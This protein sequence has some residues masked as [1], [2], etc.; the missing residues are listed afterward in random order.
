MA[1]VQEIRLHRVELKLA[2]TDD[3]M[4]SKVSWEPLVAGGASFRSHRL[5]E[6]PGRLTVR[7]TIGG[8]VFGCAFAVP[9]TLAVLAA[10]PAALMVDENG[11]MVG[12]FLLLW[13]TLFGGAG[14]FLLLGGKPLTF[15]ARAGVYF[16]GKAYVHGAGRPAD[17]QGSLSRI[18]AL[19][20][21]SEHV[22]GSGRNRSS[23][24][25]HE[26]NLVLDDGARI[27]VMDHGGNIEECAR[28][29]AALL[30]VPVWKAT[31]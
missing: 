29:L 11:W 8:L 25:S 14:W 9:G 18:H 27:N 28:K 5:H 15:D 2:D 22:S 1:E 24:T 21:L 6:S 26:L 7:R 17:E 19:Q 13:G 30:D 20:L 4:A 23:F 3:P 10:I 16:R 12:G 31:Y